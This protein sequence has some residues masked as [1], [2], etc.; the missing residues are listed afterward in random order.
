M[1]AHLVKQKMAEVDV[2][3]IWENTLPEVAA[4]EEE[5][6]MLEERLGFTL[7]PQYRSFLL[8]ANGW[9]AFKDHIDIFG[10]NDFLGGRRAI[11]A[12]ELTDSLDPLKDLCGFDKRDLMPIAVSSDDIDI[13]LMTR[14]HT[15][16]PGV[17]FWFAGGLVDKFSGFDE[18]FLAMV[19]YNRINYQ[20][21]VENRV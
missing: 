14:P 8:H 7:S 9:I 12:T 11:K 1:I 21:M 18:W 15:R 4:S 6:Q 16:E 19:D 2:N 10:I 3:C 5:L 20:K 13:M 17:I